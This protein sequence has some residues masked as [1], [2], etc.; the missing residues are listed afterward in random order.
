MLFRIFFL[1]FYHKSCIALNSCS[2][3]L[4]P[5][6]RKCV[7]YWS[8][9]KIYWANQEL[10][11]SI[12]R[13]SI[14][15][16]VSLKKNIENPQRKLRFWLFFFVWFARTYYSNVDLNS[17]TTSSVK[18][19]TMPRRASY[20]T[21]QEAYDIPHNYH[22]NNNDPRHSSCRPY[23]AD[24]YCDNEAQYQNM[25]NLDINHGRAPIL[26]PIGRNNRY[27]ITF[28]FT[29]YS[30]VVESWLPRKS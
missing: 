28:F 10:C 23:A 15:Q 8:V 30:A 14:K 12:S 29:K 19:S 6:V 2:F 11:L 26:P 4:Q 9:L 13:L 20:Y 1:D 25:E 18:S 7:N 3:S 27:V 24:S 5:A 17:S 21:N 22:K 16:H